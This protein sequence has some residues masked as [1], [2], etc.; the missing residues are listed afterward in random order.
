MAR[1]MMEAVRAV[2]EE[3]WDGASVCV[4]MGGA[5]DED[6]D[7]GRHGG[8][9]D[10]EEWEDDCFDM[11]FEYVDGEGGAVEVRD[12]NGERRGVARLREVLETNEWEG[13]D[14]DDE[15]G[16][17]DAVGESMH[18]SGD[19]EDVGF[20]LERVQMEREF[21]GLKMGLREG[22]VDVDGD[23]NEARQ[24]EEMERMMGKMMA[25]RG[26]SFFRS[27]VSHKND[28]RARLIGVQT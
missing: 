7:E 4:G 10:W 18:D 16:L 5:Q 11:G 17:E 14:G 6:E 22:E 20:T 26:M 28:A 23:G 21:A 3:G 19:G 8:E 24:V 9:V 13:V 12:R 1:E 25:V 27:G 15:A 2:V